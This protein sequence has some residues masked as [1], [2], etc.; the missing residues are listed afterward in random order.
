MIELSRQDRLSIQLKLNKA[1]LG[2]LLGALV[3]A[4]TGEAT[5]LDAIVDDSV[6]NSKRK[7]STKSVS[8][9]LMLGDDCVLSRG[10]E[11]V[12]WKLT[13]DD[14]ESAV[15]SLRHT[16]KEG[17]CFPAEFL[18]VKVPKNKDLDTMYCVFVEMGGEHGVT[19]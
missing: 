9:K 10:N 2:A 16:I 3:D 1:G 11:G 5:R 19:S 18:Q 13:L 4:S 8:L 15:A 12:V 14:F 7:S 6:F 17:W